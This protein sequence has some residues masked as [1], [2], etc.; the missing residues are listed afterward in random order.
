MITSCDA[1]LQ[2]I[3]NHK[4]Q[5][6]FSVKEIPFHE[7]KEWRFIADKQALVHK[8]GRF[9]AIKGYKATTVE[10]EIFYQPLIY[11]WEVGIQAFLVKDGDD[12]LQV[13][14]QAKTEPGN[15][16]ITQISP[17]LQVTRSNLQGV[18][19]GK[20]PKFANDFLDLK[21]KNVI[22]NQKYP[23]LGNRYYKKWNENIIIKTT[24]IES[25][26]PAFQWISINTLKKLLRYDNA[27]NNDAR[28]VL[29]LLLLRYGTSFLSS[30]SP[31]QEKL[32][33]SWNKLS[34]FSFQDTSQAAVWLQKIRS[35]YF[36]KVEEVSLL[37]LDSWK[38][39]DS[40][41]IR[42][43]GAQFSIIQ[44]AVES[45][46]EV[47]TWDQPIVNAH[48]QGFVGLICQEID[49]ILHVLFEA[50]PQIGGQQGAE[51]LPSVCLDGTAPNK[52]Q[53]DLYQLMLDPET[54]ISKCV[55][56]EEGGRFFQDDS[57][58][59]IS[60]INNFKI[61]LPENYCWLT[62]GQIRKLSYESH[63]FSDEARGILA[64]LLSYM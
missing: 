15:I 5:L 44:I 23:E 45:E 13:L 58:V 42:K 47:S 27:I 35:K 54:L 21:Y 61:T 6:R 4:Q 39:T 55:Y 31:L 56:S 50:S 34:G 63:F 7:S 29:S 59:H 52:I 38:V 37:Q 24:E 26:D 8:S 20:I 43:D 11:Q 28:L 1:A 14:M 10:G 41:I 25:D 19:D 60:L 57:L 16:G 46:R 33:L 62:I 64:I 40:K 9:F 2:W 36:L 48:Q 30:P 22:L 53:S 32:L 51:L 17:T 18:H 3:D 12:G 49:G